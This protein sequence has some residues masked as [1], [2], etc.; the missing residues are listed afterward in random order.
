MHRTQ[1][2]E[3]DSKLPT[4]VGG[5]TPHFF[6]WGDEKAIALNPL[7]TK[8]STLYVAVM[9]TQDNLRKLTT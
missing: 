4:S 3:P 9:A 2:S 5:H 8:T 6:R 7:I 1:N